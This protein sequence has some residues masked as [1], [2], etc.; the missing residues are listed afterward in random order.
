MCSGQEKGA[1]QRA[2]HSSPRP[3][4]VGQKRALL[5]VSRAGL[6]RETAPP[7]PSV[8]L[9]PWHLARLQLTREEYVERAKAQFEARNH[10]LENIGR[11]DLKPEERHDLEANYHITWGRAFMK[12][13]GCWL[14]PSLCICSRLRRHDSAHQL[15]VF[16]HH[17]EWGRASNTGCL[18]RQ[19]LGG[20]VYV[21]GVVEQEE[22]LNKVIRERPSVVLWPG[23]GSIPARSLG[24]VVGQ[25]AVDKG[26][27][28][29]AIDTTWNCAKKMVKRIPAEIPRVSLSAD[30]L[31]AERSLLY[32]IRKYDGPCEDRVCTY[33]AVLAFLEEVGD[34]DAEQR[35]S[36]LW[37]LKIKVDGVLKHKNRRA[38][39]YPS[40]EEKRKAEGFL[41]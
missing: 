30:M 28:I 26:L 18:L 1:Q 9:S 34:M 5:H 4:Y 13:P 40:E 17:K 6:L 12:C 8:E 20:K 2:L 19:G 38:V 31:P 14:F 29:V 3:R 37:N 21:S 11:A 24:E 23:E 22:A 25:E 16:M 27:V 10:F 15:A 32:P 35:E 7:D 33:E 41:L 36:L 39:Y